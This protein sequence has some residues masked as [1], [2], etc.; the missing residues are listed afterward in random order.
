MFK[1]EKIAYLAGLIDGEGSIGIHE[2]K[3]R[4]NCGYPYGRFDLR[5]S[6]LNTDS[7][8]MAWLKSN[9]GG[10]I[11]TSQKRQNPIHKLEQ[12]WR[13]HADKA[14]SLLEVCLPF[15]IVKAEQAKEAI[16]FQKTKHHA[17]KR[18]PNGQVMRL[19]SKLFEERQNYYDKM[20]ML[21]RKGIIL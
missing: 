15:L 2:S 14:S 21:N 11:W 19:D 10:W 8:L 9:F 20:K 12:H 17:V 13:L 16:A 6:I 4:K 3:P 7:R 1:T 18:Y 5:L